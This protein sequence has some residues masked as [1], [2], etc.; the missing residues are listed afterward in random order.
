MAPLKDILPTLSATLLMLTSRILVDW[1]EI[2]A[3]VENFVAGQDTFLYEDR[4]D[5][6][7]FDDDNFTRSRQYFWVIDS[8]GEFVPIIDK[9]IDHYENVLKWVCQ[10][11]LN[12]DLRTEDKIGREYNEALIEHDAT[13]KKLK[14]LRERFEGQRNRATALRDGVSPE[15]YPRLR[16]S[17]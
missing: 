5:R 16:L 7:L 4:H 6:L 2:S 14:A 13:L 8:I 9:T 17:H 1:A 3:Y 11:T 10:A 12:S 15:P